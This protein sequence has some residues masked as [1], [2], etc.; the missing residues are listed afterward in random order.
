MMVSNSCT[1]YAASALMALQRRA[2]VS[3]D[4]MVRDSICKGVRE[5]RAC[6]EE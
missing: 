3:R 2:I 5:I 6:D 1:P 4:V